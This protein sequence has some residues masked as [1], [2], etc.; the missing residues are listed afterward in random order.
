M[1]L[2]HS[3]LGQYPAYDGHPQF[4]VDWELKKR[5]KTL[6]F[7]EELERKEDTLKALNEKV[8]IVI[9]VVVV[10]VVAMLKED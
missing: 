10:V 9:F 7:Q 4:L 8:V 3:I 2:L 5:D 1:S 6:L